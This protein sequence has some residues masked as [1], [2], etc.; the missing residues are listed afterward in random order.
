MYFLFNFFFFFFFLSK[1]KNKL[2]TNDLNRVD[3]ENRDFFGDGVVCFNRS[4]LGLRKV[5][6][7]S[8]WFK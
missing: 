1:L 4:E 3:K 8:L 7:A 2:I 5:Y 6:N